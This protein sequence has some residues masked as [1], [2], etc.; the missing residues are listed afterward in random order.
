LVL[1]IEPLLIFL[2]PSYG[3]GKSHGMLGLWSGT[4][5]VTWAGNPLSDTY[6]RNVMV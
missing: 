3:A 1:P 6:T 2:D 4:L 5:G